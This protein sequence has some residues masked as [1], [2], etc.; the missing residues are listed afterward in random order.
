MAVCCFSTTAATS[1]QRLKYSALGLIAWHHTKKLFGQERRN[2]QKYSRAAGRPGVKPRNT[3]NTRKERNWGGGP[4]RGTKSHEEAG[5]ITRTR[6]DD[7]R[8]MAED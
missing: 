2:S 3:P 4:R 6:T 5:P 1:R 8:L 7:R